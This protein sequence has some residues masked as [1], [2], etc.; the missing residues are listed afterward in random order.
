MINLQAKIKRD[1]DSHALM[2]CTELENQLA[3]IDFKALSRYGDDDVNEP[4]YTVENGVAT[5]DVRGLL[6][7]ETSS[8]YRSW[9][10]TGY[11]NLADY[12]QQANDDYAVTSIVLD[13][14]SGG[15]YVAGLD[16]ITETIYQSA[17][18]IETFV[19]GDAYSAA[20][21]LAAS[22]SKITAS[23]KSGI[24]SI[25]VYGDHAE[26]SKALEDAGIKIKR[27]RSG[28]WKGA[29]NW[30]TPL[31]AEEETRL[32]DGINESASIF[33]NYVAAQRNIDVKTIQGWEGDDFSAAKAKELGLIDAIADSVAVSSST[34]QS[35]NNPEE[36]DLNELEKA[37]AEIAALKADKV[38]DEQAIADAKAAALVAQ[39]ALAASQSATRQADIDKLATD[40]GRTFTDEQVTAFKAM[41]EAQFATSVVLAT[42]VAPKAPELPDGLDKAQATNGR[43]G[44]E[45]KIMAAVAAAKAQGAK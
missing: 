36:Y 17:K 24:G 1:I 44:G 37:Q 23:K 15:G 42:P 28:R 38:K 35:N 41:D 29:F 32:Q 19:S 45:S 27:F 31:S 13:I 34:K 22:T 30:F 7:P 18:P 11:A 33:F 6:V 2:S 9:G 39:N 26:K 8:D 10:V 5:I 12:I 16:G 40:T 21:W 4:A 43:E 3:S 20:Y 14:D 25:G